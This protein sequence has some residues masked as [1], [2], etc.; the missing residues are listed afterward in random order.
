MAI[1]NLREEGG[2]AAQLRL[3]VYLIRKSKQAAHK[4]EIVAKALIL[5]K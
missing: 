1:V 5:G 4:D 3:V 2:G